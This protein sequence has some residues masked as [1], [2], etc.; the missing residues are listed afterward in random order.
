MN[1]D[2]FFYPCLGCLFILIIYLMR[3]VEDKLIKKETGRRNS[4]HAD[5][6]GNILTCEDL[7]ELT[8]LERKVDEFY[9]K[10]CYLNK[11]MA[12]IMAADLCQR[13]DD[14]RKVIRAAAKL[15]QL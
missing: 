10:Y 6:K 15:I 8:T 4:L 3:P 12:M 5:I 2:Y 7:G 9:H 11:T 1:Y 14:R 13:V